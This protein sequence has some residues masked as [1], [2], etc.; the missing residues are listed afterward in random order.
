MTDKKQRFNILVCIDGSPSSYRG[1]RYALKFSMDD[2]DTD[3]SLLYVRPT[4]R[5]G[6]SEG[7]NMELARENMLDWDLELP[8]L[9]SLKKA[10][11]ILIENELLGE[12]W[13][14]KDISKKYRGSRLGDHILQY[15]NKSSGQKISLI[16]RVE[17]S[18]LV[19]ILNEAHYTKYDLVI[20]SASDD[21]RGGATI[22]NRTAVGVASEHDGT[23]IIARELEAG[24]GHLVCMTNSK[25]SL[26]LALLDAEIAARCGCPIHLYAV[27][28]TQEQKNATEKMLKTAKKTLEDHGYAVASVQ[29]ELGDPVARIIEH[30]KSHSLIV[31]AP[32]KHSFLK[33][34]FLGSISNAVLKKASNSVMIVR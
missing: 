29:M 25:T 12:D 24:H 8:G 11:D 6:S 10:R 17:S 5:S 15:Y 14:D 2:T 33:R 16:V 22:D 1:L 13:E 4:D 7:L 27:A 23:V 34:M 31:M 28:P 19:G 21:D 3:I 30:G 18:V 9:S 26:G 20:V 32:S